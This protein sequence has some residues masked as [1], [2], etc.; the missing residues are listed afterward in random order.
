VEDFGGPA[1][2]NGLDIETTHQGLAISES[3]W[4]VM[5]GHAVAGVDKFEAQSKP[6]GRPPVSKDK[7]KREAGKATC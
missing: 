5:E 6:L 2:Y 1:F 4:E 7:R 3:D